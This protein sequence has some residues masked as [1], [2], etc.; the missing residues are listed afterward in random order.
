MPNF[1]SLF[2][3][4]KH[5]RPQVKR[6]VALFTTALLTVGLAV[7]GVSA[8][9]NAD[10]GTGTTTVKYGTT[11]VYNGAHSWTVTNTDNSKALKNIGPTQ[12]V[13]CSSYDTGAGKP[14]ANG[15]SYT[16]TSD[17]VNNGQSCAYIQGDGGGNGNWDTVPGEPGKRVCSAEPPTTPIPP[18]TPKCIANPSYSY[19]YDSTN[20]SG[21][22]TVSGGKTGDTLC[23]PLYVR[24]ATWDYDLPTNGDTP[25]WPQTLKGYQD[26][27]VNAIGSFPY[28]SPSVATCQQQDVYATFSKDGFAALALPTHLFGPQNPKEPEFLHGTLP[29]VGPVPTYRADPSAGCTVIEPTAS[30]AQGACVYNDGNSTSSVTLTYDNSAS[31]VP[32]K[33]TVDST[34]GDNSGYDRTVP[35]KSVVT[36]DA[37][38]MLYPY[39]GGYTVFANGKK[40]ELATTSVDCTPRIE[41]TASI[42]YGEC[43][44]TDGAA[45]SRKVEITFDNSKSNVPVDFAVPYF[46]QYD[47]KVAAGQTV[48]F[49]VANIWAEGGGYAVTAGGK[50]FDLKISA[51]DPRLVALVDPKVADEQCVDGQSSGGSIT[52]ALNDHVKYSIVGTSD[53]STVNLTPTTAKNALPAG[54]YTVTATATDGFGIDGKS[55]W[56]LKI[57]PAAACGELVTFPLVTPVLSSTQ[58]S[59]D[60]DGS[61]TLTDLV[62]EGEHPLV[63]SVDGKVTAPGT[64]SAKAGTT[65]KVSVATSGPDFGFDS[66]TQT[67][68]TLDFAAA[69]SCDQLTTLAFTGANGDM[70]GLMIAGLLLL[71][72]GAGVYTGSRLK[73]RRNQ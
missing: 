41:P 25:S 26:V 67:D 61:Y 40:F 9:A 24:A 47:Q 42:A 51:C 35:A 54:S 68:W 65:V 34:Y 17:S 52:V 72:A 23:T 28:A 6:T 44:Y 21:I 14:C 43:V 1:L 73:A 7:V 10:T 20:S 57:E 18:V 22:I 29:G 56:T 71:L 69:K 19:S 39:S 11:F 38:P 31:N 33:F 45:A 50:S 59:C 58:P 30:I 70:G 8:A 55:S 63:W 49:E 64:Y 16:Y 12:S 46:P 36:V 32:V 66:E 13:L 53:G 15:A 62:V 4:A 2:T 60:A 48:T 3:P 37:Q 27:T 5:R